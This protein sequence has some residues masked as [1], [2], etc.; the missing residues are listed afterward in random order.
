MYWPPVLFA[1]PYRTPKCRVGRDFPCVI[2]GDRPVRGLTEAPI[3]WPYAY[4][5]VLFVSSS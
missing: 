5:A 4:G 1:G 3:L 2:N